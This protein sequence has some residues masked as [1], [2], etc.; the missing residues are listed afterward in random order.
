MESTITDSES[1]SVL[2]RRQRD[3]SRRE[4]PLDRADPSVAISSAAA[5]Y[6]N[7]GRWG[8]DDVLGTLNFIDDAKRWTPPS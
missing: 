4:W 7:W 6:G 1:A 8:A 5:A 3:D 2:S